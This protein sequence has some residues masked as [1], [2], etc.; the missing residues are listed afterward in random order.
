MFNNKYVYRDY[1]IHYS[2]TCLN[3]LKFAYRQ[4]TGI[5]PFDP[6]EWSKELLDEDRK[7]QETEMPEIILGPKSMCEEVWIDG[8]DRLRSYRNSFDDKCCEIKK[9]CLIRN[10][11]PSLI[12]NILEEKDNVKR[13]NTN[14]FDKKNKNK[15]IEFLIGNFWHYVKSAV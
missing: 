5:A 3:G 7:K 9:D 15:T 14:S 11:S 12:T 13:Q 1:T 2:A 10:G 6:S 8:I 4:S